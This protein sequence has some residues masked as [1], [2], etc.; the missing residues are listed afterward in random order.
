LRCNCHGFEDT[1]D[2]CMM[3]AQPQVCR[4]NAANSA[5]RPF[6]QTDRSIIEILTKSRIEE[7]LW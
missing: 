3:K 7:L 2:T 5:F 4:R 6:D 1:P